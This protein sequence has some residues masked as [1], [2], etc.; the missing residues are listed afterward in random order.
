MGNLD[1]SRLKQTLAAEDAYL[2]GFEQFQT[3]ISLTDQYRLF[4]A[5]LAMAP[6]NDSL[7]ARIF[8]QYS[9]IAATRRDASERARLFK[10]ANLLYEQGTAQRMPSEG[11]N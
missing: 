11:G 10:K 4:D 7:R 1:M 8:S 9:H 2:L 3:G 6:W 5:I